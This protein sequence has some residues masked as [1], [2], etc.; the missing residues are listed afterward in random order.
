M[1]RR[2]TFLWFVVVGVGFTLLVVLSLAILFWQQLPPDDHSIIIRIVRQNVGY[3]FSAAVL[4]LAGLGFALDWLFRLYILPDRQNRFRNPS[5][6]CRQS[7]PSNHHRGQPRHYAI[8]RH[9]Q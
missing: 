2:N 4:L 5:D 8:G 6:A 9:H 1:N 3:I 7:W